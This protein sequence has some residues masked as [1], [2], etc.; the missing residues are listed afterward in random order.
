MIHAPTEQPGS[1]DIYKVR[2]NPPLGRRHSTDSALSLLLHPA[3]PTHAV[4]KH[5]HYDATR[6]GLRPQASGE[7]AL[8]RTRRQ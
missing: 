8:D 4:P 1:K 2:S 6:L 3:A 5:A 7:H